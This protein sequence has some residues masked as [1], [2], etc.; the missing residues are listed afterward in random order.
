MKII[1]QKYGGSSVSDIDKIKFVAKKIIETKKKGYGVVVVVSAMGKT[2]DSLLCLAKEIN[3]SPSNRE[4][5][6]LLSVGERISMTLLTMAIQFFGEDAISLTGSQ[7]GIITN[8]SHS[9]A[10]IIEVRPFRIQDELQRGKIVI[11]AGYQGMSYTREVTTLGRGGSDTTAVALCAALGAEF[12][13][14]YSDVDGVYS[15]DPKIVKNAKHFEEIGYEEILALSR[16]GAKVLNKDAILFAKKNKIAL[17]CKSTFNENGKETI[18]RKDRAIY[19]SQ[20]IGITHKNNAYFLSLTMKKTP[21]YNIINLMKNFNIEPYFYT[22]QSKEKNIFNCILIPQ[23]PHN[24]NM[25][26]ESLLVQGFDIVKTDR[27]LGFV[28]LVGDSIHNS[29]TLKDINETI[30]EVTNPLFVASTDMAL[31]F[32]VEEKTT[33]DIIKILHKK[34][35]E[36]S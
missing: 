8:A 11:V 20:F 6:M 22:L 34:F 26:F 21:Y 18:I 2:T 30:L 24:I 1:V 27:P 9:N 12:C 36:R 25:F 28:S 4:L 29:Q 3:P 19:N 17:Y 16:C 23:T 13:E 35:I 33:E 32:L 15:A 5:D 7:S 10:K 14:I 31:S